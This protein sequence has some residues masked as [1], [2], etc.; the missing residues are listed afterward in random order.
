MKNYSDG[1]RHIYPA[2]WWRDVANDLGISVVVELQKRAKNA[3]YLFCMNC[4]DFVLTS[5]TCGKKCSAY[6]PRNGKSGCCRWATRGF[7]GTGEFYEIN[8]KGKI[9]RTK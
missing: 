6:A 5:D 7:T 4:R 2:S 3:E 8:E 9:R 1:E